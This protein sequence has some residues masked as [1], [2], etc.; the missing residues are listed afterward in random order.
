MN[1]FF[2]KFFFLVTL[3]LILSPA[4]A[5][6]RGKVIEQSSLKSSILGKE[7]RYTVY[8]PADYDYSQ[9]SYPIVYLLHGFSDDNTGWLQFG[10]INR[11]A[12]KGIAEGTIPPMIIVTPNA[13]SSWY[14]NSMDG[15]EKYEDFFVREFIPAV[16]KSFR[17][18]SQKRYRG[19]AGLSMGGYGALIYA[20][21]YPELFASSAPMSAAIFPDDEIT[22]M[23]DTYFDNLLGR[24]MGE[25][26]KG[27]D[28]LNQHWY[29]NSVLKIVDN[30]QA[31][32]L[33]KVRY[34]IDCGDDDFL[35]KGNCLLHLALTEKK[36]PH[37]FRVRDGGHNWT[38]WRTGITDALQFIG[39]SFTQ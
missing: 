7:V 19:V 5:Q 20:L 28:R 4:F 29:E 26:L 27:K 2:R 25:G 23:N 21:K 8:L 39:E 9:R 10:E 37:E 30:K 13:D 36:V 12:D 17:V 22:G 33:K 24:S 38:Y 1:S 35:T 18:K 3:T 32:D 34:W 11:F 31:D 6:H 14:I 16:E 15:R